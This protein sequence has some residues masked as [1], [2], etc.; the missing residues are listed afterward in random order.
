VVR[1]FRVA[2][3]GDVVLQTIIWESNMSS[4]AFEKQLHLLSGLQKFPSVRLSPLVVC[5]ASNLTFA[6]HPTERKKRGSV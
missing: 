3:T 4:Q 2:I 6:S 1:P 5:M